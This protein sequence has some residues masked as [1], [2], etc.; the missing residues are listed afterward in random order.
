MFTG[1]HKNVRVQC[2]FFLFQ[3][4]KM[5]AIV[6]IKICHHTK[7]GVTSGVRASNK[8]WEEPKALVADCIA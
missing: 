2:T 1:K 5:L 7:C 4:G 8:S 6:S 3:R